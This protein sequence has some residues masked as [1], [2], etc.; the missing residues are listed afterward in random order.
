MLCQHCKKNEASY[1]AVKIVNGVQTE[2]H[3]CSECRRK[4]GVDLTSVDTFGV[5][6]DIFGALNGFFGD[7]LLESATCEHCG[8]TSDRFLRTGRVGCEHCYDKFNTLILPRLQQTQQKIR[9]V[10]KT[11]DKKSNNPLS[12]YDKLKMELD[13]AI[14]V[15][16]YEK[17]GR[18]NEQLKKLKENK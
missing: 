15:E 1:H 6:G 13:K 10:G 11:P 4:L 18:I 12:E 17:A 9:H 16:D 7:G 3:L 2:T 5:F 14:E 8:T